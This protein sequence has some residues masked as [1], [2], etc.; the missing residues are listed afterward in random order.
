MTETAENLE[1]DFQI[2]PYEKPVTSLVDV[3]K[4]RAVQEVQ[5]ALIIAKKFPRDVNMAYTRIME[6]CKRPSLAEV[7]IYKYPRG[8]EIIRGPSIRLAEV[9]AQ[10]WGNIEYG[11]REIERRQG[12]SVMEAFCWD[13]ET[14]SRSRV[15]FEVPHEYSAGG[16]IKKLTDPRDIR[17]TIANQGSR[18]MRARIEAVIPSDIFEKA[19]KACLETIAGGKKEPL[20]DKIQRMVL[21]FKELGVSQ[22]MIEEKLGHKLDLATVEEIVDM[23]AIYNSIKDKQMKK[24]DFFNCGEEEKPKSTL[25]DKL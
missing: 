16:K 17:E 12:V 25:N 15:T 14:N 19:E 13:M 4:M 8:G 22:D 2:Q 20:A 9:I 5:A 11:L 7:A 10:A 18:F 1:N 23:I 3:E 21:R 6:A 24:S